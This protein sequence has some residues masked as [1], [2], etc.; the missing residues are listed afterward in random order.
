[1]AAHAEGHLGDVA[2]PEG[3]TTGPGR[4]DH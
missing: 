1:V 3:G 4:T 2:G